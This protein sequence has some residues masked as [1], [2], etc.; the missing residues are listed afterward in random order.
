MFITP[1]YVKHKDKRY[2]L[3]K[4]VETSSMKMFARFIKF[5]LF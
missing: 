5:Y 2:F 1:F 4:T 3:Y